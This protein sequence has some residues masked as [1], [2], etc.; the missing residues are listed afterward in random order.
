MVDEAFMPFAEIIRRIV[1]F[2]TVIDDTD[3]GIRLSVQ[4]CEIELPVE[5]DVEAREHG[6]VRIGSTPPLYNVNTSF[7]PSLHRLRFTVQA[8]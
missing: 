1:D 8:D 2:R 3:L 5:L 7:K 6:A 4:S